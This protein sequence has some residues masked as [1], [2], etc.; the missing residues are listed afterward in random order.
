M[1]VLSIGAIIASGGLMKLRWRCVSDNFWVTEYRGLIIRWD[2]FLFICPGVGE[3]H[4][5]L[6]KILKDVDQFWR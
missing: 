1:Y 6:H 5:D 2:G 4:K 3:A